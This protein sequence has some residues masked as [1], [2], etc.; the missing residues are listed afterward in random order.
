MPGYASFLIFVCMALAGGPAWAAETVSLR[1]LLA[2]G[3]EIK[4]VAVIPAEIA[5]RTSQQI[6]ADGAVITLQNGAALAV[7]NYTLG[8]L[9]LVDWEVGCLK[10]E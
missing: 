2:D 6:Q 9:L 5:T 8:A 10:A 1:Q 4:D 3:Y 7:C